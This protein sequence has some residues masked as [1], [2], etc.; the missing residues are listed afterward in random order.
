MVALNV[1]MEGGV[2][3]KVEGTADPGSSMRGVT[4]MYLQPDMYSHPRYSPHS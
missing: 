1:A 2:G 3:A 4:G